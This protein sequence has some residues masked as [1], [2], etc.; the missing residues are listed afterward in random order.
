MDF[1]SFL[2]SMC[3]EDNGKR[4]RLE[5]EI[6]S[7]ELIKPAVSTPGHSKLYKLSL[8]DQIYPKIYIPFVYFYQNDDKQQ[9]SELINHGLVLKRREILKQS[10]SET[11]TKFYP[12]AG[13][14]S[15]DGRFI[16][17]N[18]EGVYYVEARVNDRLFDF[19]KKPDNK[20][21][22]QLLPF[23]PSSKELW[24]MTYVTM[25]QATVFGCG[26]FAI[27]L[28]NS[29]KIMDGH[30]YAT[31]VKAWAATARGC[32]QLVCPHFLSTSIFLPKYPIQQLQGVEEASYPLSAQKREKSVTRRFVFS[33]SSLMALKKKTS[34]PTRVIA[35]ACL[36]WKCF[37]TAKL[38]S[39][40]SH[41]CEAKSY[42]VYLAVN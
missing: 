24:S 10:L 34:A 13:K 6:I 27:G 16:D 28:Y 7:V 21:I 26:G 2:F 38:I 22:H 4:K 11:L 25:I 20:L 33:A 42:T 41:G 39:S 30:S 17:C 32:S 8:L 3:S 29:H 14:I 5:V 37:I 1:I 15:A 18:D 36:I 23:D 9:H 40:T 31:L 19:L 12:L 35:V